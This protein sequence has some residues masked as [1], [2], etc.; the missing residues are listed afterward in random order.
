MKNLN[1]FS[2]EPEGETKKE[3]LTYVKDNPQFSETRNWGFC[4][5]QMGGM[6]NDRSFYK[7]DRN[8]KALCNG[9]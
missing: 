7:R 6:F 4:I 8:D 5:K 2:V 9:R 3:H 1:P